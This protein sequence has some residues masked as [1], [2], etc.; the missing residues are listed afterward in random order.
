[1]WSCKVCHSTNVND[2]AVACSICR[3]SK[4]HVLPQPAVTTTPTAKPT[5]RVWGSNEQVSNRPFGY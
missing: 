4:H 5:T 3:T 2:A 1:M